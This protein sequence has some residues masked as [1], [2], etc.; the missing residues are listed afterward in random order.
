L[1]A[2]RPLILKIAHDNREEVSTMYQAERRDRPA[3]VTVIAVLNIIGAVI[4]GLIGLA[5]IGAGDPDLTAGGLF[6]LV[7]AAFTLT[8]AVGLLR[9]RNWARITATIMYGLNTLMAFIELVMGNPA[10]LVGLG[11][12]LTMLIYLNR[13]HVRE[14]FTMSLPTGEPSSPLGD[15]EEPQRS[16]GD[17]RVDTI[18]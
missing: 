1:G 3:G 6:L 17:V 15:W 5:A 11:V 2:K 8:V 4:L 9:L 12:A 10:A 18:S 16:G 13:E 7:M 14:A